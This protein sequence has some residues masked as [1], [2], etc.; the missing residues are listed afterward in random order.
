MTSD[1]Q[2]V[3]GG[4]APVKRRGSAKADDGQSI[5]DGG[6]RVDWLARVFGLNRA[7]VVTKLVKAP[8][9]RRDEM[10]NPFYDVAEVAGFLVPPRLDK[11]AVIDSI[12]ATDLPERLR[13]GFWNA[14]IKEMKFR[15]LAGELWPTESVM[16]VLA[17]TFQ[18]IAAK[19]KLWVDDLE[20]V[21]QLNDQQ[22][23]AL[24]GMVD[25]LIA[26]VKGG[27][28]ERAES[29]VTESYVAELDD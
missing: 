22:R 19:T 20:E 17:D 29:K 14:K 25:A 10:G 9:K 7:T 5:R 23:H 16:E 6:V 21:E 2:D 18:L 8:V 15:V 11:M 12:K 4:P 3:L 13:E 1:F 27:L 24:M 26:E 28:V